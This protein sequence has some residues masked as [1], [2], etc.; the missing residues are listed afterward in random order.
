MK[1]FFAVIILFFTITTQAQVGVGTN[2]PA[3]TAILDLNSTNKGLLPPR[4]TG[5]QRDAITNPATGLIIYCTNCGLNGGEPEYYNGHIWVNLVGGTTLSAVPNFSPGA[6]AYGGKV[7]YLYTSSDPGFDPNVDHG[8]IAAVEDQGSAT[9]GVG[10]GNNP[11]DYGISQTNNYRGG[12]YSDW[13]LPTL[14]E[15]NK[16][17][18]NRVAIGEFDLSESYWSSDLSGGWQTF[19]NFS[20]GNQGTTNNIYNLHKVRAVRTF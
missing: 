8:L 11:T 4:M 7:A 19:I 10:I 18:T 2:T 20:N 1:L 15:L 14:S 6:N 17:Y 12:G 16:L 13:R 9:N 5:N 3:A